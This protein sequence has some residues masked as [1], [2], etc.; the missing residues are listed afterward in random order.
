[1]THISGLIRVKSRLFSTI[2]N[3]RIH[4]LKICHP[5]ASKALLTSRLAFWRDPDLAPPRLEWLKE[6]AQLLKTEESWWQSA[7]ELMAREG[8]ALDEAATRLKIAITSQEA[9]STQRSKPF[10][11]LLL[12]ERNRFFREIAS[13]R[14]WSKATAVG[15]LLDC[16][17]RLR[18]EGEFDKAA[19]VIL[20]AAKILGWVGE[21]GNVQ[22]FAGMTGRELEQVREKLVKRVKSETSPA[23]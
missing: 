12:T 4:Q 11:R 16:C 10:Q 20:K 17:E 6:S 22:V 21:T 18:Q 23:N 19:E 3:F 8:L 9:R 7:A 15:I 14:E 2:F 13:N 1:M 5:I